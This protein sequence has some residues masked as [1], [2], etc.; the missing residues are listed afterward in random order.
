MAVE[1]VFKELPVQASLPVI[2]ALPAS[3]P[4]GLLT[5]HE[6]GSHARIFT[7]ADAPHLLWKTVPLEDM[8][9]MSDEEEEKWRVL[10]QERRVMLAVEKR[11]NNLGIPPDRR[12]FLPL[13]AHHTDLRSP[14]AMFASPS[15]ANAPVTPEEAAAMSRVFA[16][17]MP[18]LNM[19]VYGD[20]R[21]VLP[22]C[23]AICG[24]IRSSQLHQ[25]HTQ[26]LLKDLALHQPHTQA[27]LKDLALLLLRG[28]VRLHNAAILL[29]ILAED[30]MSSDALVPILDRIPAVRV[31]RSTGEVSLLGELK[32]LLIRQPAPIITDD[33]SS[34][35]CD[36]RMIDLGHCLRHKP[37]T[38]PPPTS[39][40]RLPILASIAKEDQ[41]YDQMWTITPHHHA[42]EFSVMLAKQWAGQRAK[43]REQ[44][45]SG[46]EEVYRDGWDVG[47]GLTDDGEVDQVEARAG[48]LLG[49]MQERGL[50]VEEPQEDGTVKAKMWIGEAAIVGG[51]GLETLSVLVGELLHDHM[52]RLSPPPRGADKDCHRRRLSILNGLFWEDTLTRALPVVSEESRSLFQRPEPCMQWARDVGSKLRELVVD[53]LRPMPWERMERLPKGLIDMDARLHEM[54]EMVLAAHWGATSPSFPAPITDAN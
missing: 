2:G 29:E 54:E 46:V 7:T 41:E 30:N 3:P 4:S 12:P 40:G 38:H 24:A 34:I 48:Q 20:L 50:D 27:L 9:G 5:Q 32:D 17:Q 19:S 52:E 31:D 21:K 43:R 36:E 18:K 28:L 10:R 25:P 22:W 15:P 35:A 1:A 39:I 16:I 42:P 8:E 13:L 37:T 14:A 6:G 47:C 44:E 49:A 45:A 11:S 51:L 33:S 53:S 26:A 23:A